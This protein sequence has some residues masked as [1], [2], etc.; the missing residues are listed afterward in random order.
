MSDVDVTMTYDLLDLVCL[1]F[2]LCVLKYI[3]WTWTWTI[4]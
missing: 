4:C 1:F 2:I 3:Y